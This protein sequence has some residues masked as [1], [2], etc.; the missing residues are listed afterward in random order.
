MSKLKKRIRIT[1]AK[2]GDRFGVADRD[3]PNSFTI[4][5]HPDHR[6]QKSLLNTLVHE[7]LHCG[8]WDLPEKKVRHL[9]ACVVSVLWRQGFRRAKG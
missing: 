3:G 2:L 7:A 8:D 6:T 9:T 1:K 5:I 4:R